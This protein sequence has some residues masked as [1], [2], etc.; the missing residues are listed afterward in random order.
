MN[1]QK[2]EMKDE[3]LSKVNGGLFDFTDEKDEVKPKCD[4]CGSENVSRCDGEVC[5]TC[6]DCGK[7]VKLPLDCSTFLF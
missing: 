4:A 3:E 7:K 5:F 6:G 1:K 2:P